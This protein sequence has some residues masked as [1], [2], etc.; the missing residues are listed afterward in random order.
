M[1]LLRALGLTAF[2][3]FAGFAAAAAVVKQILPSRG[4]EESDEIALV[5][6][7]DGASLKSRAKA[8]TGGSLL[9]WFG[10]V[11]VDLREARLAPGAHLR[12]HSLF[13]GIAIRV[14]PGWRVESRVTALG[15]G[16]AVG[17]PDVEDATA[18][19]LTLDG[20]SLA[21]GIAVGTRAADAA[22]ES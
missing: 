21:G 15:G 22:F 4:D 14:P 5:A 20:F 2:G 19:T 13:G 7:F 9:A 18:P 16:I 6:I 11:A 8:F 1:R 3:A 17:A 12:L 10:G